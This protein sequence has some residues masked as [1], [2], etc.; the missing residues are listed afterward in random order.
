MTMLTGIASLK[1]LMSSIFYATKLAMER[2]INQ[3]K[4]QPNHF[5][6]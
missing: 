3:L 2:A 6:Y 5:T 4:Q 1:K